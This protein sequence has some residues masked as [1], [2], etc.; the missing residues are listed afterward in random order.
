MI[1]FHGTSFHASRQTLSPYSAICTGSFN[2]IHAHV[3]AN[4]ARVTALQRSYYYPGSSVYTDAEFDDM[5]SGSKSILDG[6]AIST[7]HFVNYI[8]EK[9][10]MPKSAKIAKVVALGLVNGC[11]HLSL[12]SDLE[13][14]LKD[15]Q[16][17]LEDDIKNFIFY[18]VFLLYIR[19]FILMML[20]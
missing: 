1:F 11:N 4:D 8:V 16:P 14:I 19:S 3:A 7:A 5:K 9:H 18:G 12:F 2:R 6:W 20:I 10:S 17:V 15:L 13:V